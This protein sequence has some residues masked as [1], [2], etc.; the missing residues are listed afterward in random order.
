VSA[1]ELYEDPHD[2]HEKYKK[3]VD[4]IVDGGIIFAENSTIIDF[5]HGGAEIIRM[6]KGTVDWLDEI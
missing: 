4:L 6:G 5:S 3:Q 1:E 2:L